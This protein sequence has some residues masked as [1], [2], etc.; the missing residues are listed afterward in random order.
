MAVKLNNF[1][2]ILFNY[3]KHNWLLTFLG[4]YFIISIFLFSYLNIN[5]AIP[6]LIRLTTGFQCP[7]C[8]LSHAFAHMIKLEFTEAWVANKIS[9]VVLPLGAY[10]VVKDFL[11]FSK[12]QLIQIDK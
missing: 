10:Y 6:C 1:I 12:T 8:G 11:S 3:A 9:F 2:G 4:A 7:G 5:I